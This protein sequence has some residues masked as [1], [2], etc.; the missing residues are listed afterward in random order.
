MNLA[1]IQTIKNLI[2]ISGADRIELAEL[3]GKGWKV[4]VQ[5]GLYKPGDLVIFVEPDTWVPHDVA[6]FLTK[7]EPKFYNG[8]VGN[9]L[10]PVK[11]KGVLSVG[12]ILPLSLL[13]KEVQKGD[14]VTSDLGIQKWEK[15]IDVTIKGEPQDP[16]P[17][18][19]PKT[20]E[21]NLQSKPELLDEFKKIDGDIYITEKIDGTSAT[22]FYYEAKF[23]V[24]SRNYIIKY[25][26]NAYWEIEKKYRIGDK[27]KYS[28]M[29]IAIQ[30]EI[31]GEKIQTNPLGIRGIDF[32]VFDI[33]DVPG[34]KYL[35]FDEIVSIC[36]ELGLKT[37]PLIYEGEFKKDWNIDYLV[38]MSSGC[39]AN[40]NTQREGIVVRPKKYT[41]CDLIKRKLSMK[42]LNPNYKDLSTTPD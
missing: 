11:M 9:R 28:K 35:G 8:V 27:L 22:F 34:Q 14:D 13:K 20:D 2:P 21:I 1:T 42:V 32:M 5:K 16:M 15:P 39:Y 26:E 17:Y 37:V 40:T 7:G 12:L 30:G 18:Y 23:N 19:I 10:R 25:G 3:E 24:C 4:I 31:F 33:F 38:S 36:K 41:F 29:E 6:P